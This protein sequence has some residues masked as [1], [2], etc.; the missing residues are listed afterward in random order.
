VDFLNPRE[1]VSTWSHALWLLLALP[2]TLLLWRRGSGDRTKQLSLLTYGLSLAFCSAASTLYHG[3]RPTGHRLATFALLDYIGIYFLIAG[4]YTPIAWNLLRGPWRRGILVLVWLWAA[5][6]TLLRLA[7]VTLPP[8]LST[9]LYL[10]MGWGAVF[11]YFEVARRLSCRALL[12]IPVGGLLYSLGA[13]CNLLRQPVL[14][15]GVFQAHELFHLFVLAGSL[16]HF[17][18]VLRVVV[19]FAPGPGMPS[20]VP[21]P[22]A[23]SSAF[24]AP[25]APSRIGG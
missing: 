3:V 14:W 25:G 7:D 15:P 17:R 8:W 21:H 19:P 1:P 2:G 20:L 22:R 6:G 4:S 10:A 16:V 11:C 9:G 12:P 24:G 13:V 5:A 18:F 23:V